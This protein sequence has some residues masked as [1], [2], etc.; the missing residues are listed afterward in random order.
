M[1]NDKELVEVWR[2]EFIGLSKLY[3]DTEICSNGLFLSRHAE[4]MFDGF[5]LARRSQPSVVLPRQI[6]CRG[7]YFDLEGYDAEEMRA[8]LTAEGIKYTVSKD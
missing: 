6:N 2:K 7:I 5:C 3:C 4:L 1:N 8:A